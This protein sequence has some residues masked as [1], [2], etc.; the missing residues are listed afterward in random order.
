MYMRYYGIKL[1]IAGNSNKLKS[2]NH[3]VGKVRKFNSKIVKR[4]NIETPS[5]HIHGLLH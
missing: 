4:D 3:T 1:N 5:T 2:K